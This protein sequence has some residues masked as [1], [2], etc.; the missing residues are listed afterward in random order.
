VTLNDYDNATQGNSGQACKNCHN[1][2]AAV[3]T[4]NVY[5]DRKF[6][7]FMFQDPAAGPEPSAAQRAAWEAQFGVADMAVAQ[8]S[9]RNRFGDVADSSPQKTAIGMMVRLGVMSGYPD[10][11]FHPDDTMTR[12][13]FAVALDKVSSLAAPATPPAFTDLS[14]GSRVEKAAGAVVSAGLLTA[15]DGRFNPGDDVSSD[16]FH[17]ALTHAFPAGLPAGAADASPTRGEA[18][19]ILFAALQAKQ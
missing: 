19:Q 4:V 7:G 9:T 12:A 6:G 17:A 2:L 1:P 3:P 10:G 15:S 5:L 14:A 16:E 11:K 8:E 18:A 13:Q